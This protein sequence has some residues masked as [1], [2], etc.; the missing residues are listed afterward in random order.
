MTEVMHTH[1]EEVIK[2]KRLLHFC[3]HSESS[4]LTMLDMHL[5]KKRICHVVNR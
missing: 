5:A 1:R 4:K 3:D 2:M